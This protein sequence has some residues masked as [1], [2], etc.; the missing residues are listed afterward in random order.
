MRHLEGVCRERLQRDLQINPKKFFCRANDAFDRLL[1][2]V[3]VPRE[4]RVK[5]TGFFTEYFPL[6]AESVTKEQFPDDDFLQFDLPWPKNDG[7]VNER[8]D[9]VYKQL[10]EAVEG[11]KEVKKRVEKACFDD[12]VCKV[13]PSKS[14]ADAQL[15]LEQTS[16]TLNDQELQVSF[17][18]KLCGRLAPDEK[19][20]PYFANKEFDRKRREI[21]LDAGSFESNVNKLLKSPSFETQFANECLKG[22]SAQ[23][24]ERV[25]KWKQHVENPF[26]DFT[27]FFGSI[28]DQPSDAQAASSAEVE[29]LDKWMGLEGKLK[30]AYESKNKEEGEKLLANTVIRKASLKIHPDH[31]SR[32]GITEQEATEKFNEFTKLV[33]GAKAYFKKL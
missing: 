5:C 25:K 21:E 30:V 4:G 13:V 1:F 27:N 7:S 2:Q 19:D 23:F 16:V 6:R 14:M 22:L 31:A 32:Q 3:I 8:T 12:N 11:W 33:A 17:H 18:I 28:D 29:K 9:R 26:P 20:T 24:D 15:E 10:K